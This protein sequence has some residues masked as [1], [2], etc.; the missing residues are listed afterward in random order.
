MWIKQLIGVRSLTGT[1]GRPAGKFC[2]TSIFIVFGNVQWRLQTFFPANTGIFAF[3]FSWTL[4]RRGLSIFASLL[5]LLS[6]T[7]SYNFWWL[8]RYF[9]VTGCL[10]D[11]LKKQ[12]Q[13]TP[14]FWISLNWCG[15]KVCIY[16][17]H[18]NMTMDPALHTMRTGSYHRQDLS[19]F[20]LWWPTQ[21]FHIFNPDV[22]TFIKFQVRRALKTMNLKVFFFFFLFFWA[23][24]H[25]IYFTLYM[26]I[27]CTDSQWVQVG[28]K[29]VNVD[30]AWF[31]F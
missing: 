18:E 10:I 7:Y 5:P 27:W 31:A 21:S 11:R 15:D 20:A 30:C 19:N 9:E 2:L 12:N 8:S 24:S 25:L 1:L 23:Y 14:P 26:R 22:P 3:K 4:F 16:G 28:W 29:R 13:K 6:C 17:F